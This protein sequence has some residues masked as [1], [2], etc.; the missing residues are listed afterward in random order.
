MNKM[1]IIEKPPIV[2]PFLEQIMNDGLK[3]AAGLTF[4]VCSPECILYRGLAAKMAI[5]QAITDHLQAFRSKGDRGSMGLKTA[6]RQ[7]NG[8]REKT[9][10]RQDAPLYGALRAKKQAFHCPIFLVSDVLRNFK[11]YGG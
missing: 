5:L 1:H 7:G 9:S 10:H 2:G 6:K 11:G 4:G 8:G 3:N